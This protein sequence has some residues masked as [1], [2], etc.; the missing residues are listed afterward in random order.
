M[1]LLNLEE[2]LVVVSQRLESSRDEPGV[3]LTYYPQMRDR[4]QR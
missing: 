4:R 3:G 2:E 1:G